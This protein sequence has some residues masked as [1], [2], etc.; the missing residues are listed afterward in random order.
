MEFKTLKID[1][2]QKTCFIDDEEVHLTKTEYNLL[3]FLLSKPDY[4]YSREE[5]IKNVW[6]TKVSERAVDTNI[7]RLRNKLGKYKENIY[8]RLGFGYSF[9]TK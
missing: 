6:T 4:I 1:Q 7:K 9:K 8:T 5:I 3:I 2:D